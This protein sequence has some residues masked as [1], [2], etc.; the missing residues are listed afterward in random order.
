MLPTYLDA[1]AFDSVQM[2][3]C[4]RRVPLIE[5]VTAPQTLPLPLTAIDCR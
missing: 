3:N 4:F 2:I 1:I 5:R